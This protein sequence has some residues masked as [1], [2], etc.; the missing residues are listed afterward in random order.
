M[1][2][3][4]EGAA[5]DGADIYLFQQL[6]EA[7]SRSRGRLLVVGIL[8][9]AFDEYAQRLARDLRDEW[10]KVQGRFVDLVV[11][12][13]GDEQ[14]ELLATA[15][16]SDH[17]AKR[18]APLGQSIAK[19]VR[20]GRPSASENLALT[21]S[22]CAPL[23][24]VVAALLGPISRRRFGQN[25]R[26]LFGF[27]N[28]AEPFGFQDFLRDAEDRDLFWPDRLWEYL[29]VNLEPAILASPDGHRWSMAV[30]AVERCVA[31][32]PSPIHLQILKTIALLDLFRE[33]SGL[34][35]SLELLTNCVEGNATEAK[36]SAALK[37]LQSWSFVIFRKHLSCYAIH[38]GS[39]FDIEQALSEAL[40]SIRE[41]NFKQ[42][43]ALAGLQPV[44]AKRHYHSTGALRWFD[45]DLV[46]LAEVAE[47][48]KAPIPSGGA[49]GRF[50]LAVPTANEI[51]PKA[52]KICKEAMAT[53]TGDVVIGLS[54][55]SWQVMRLAREFLAISKVSE[56]RPELSGDAVA[57]REVYARIAD[58]RARLESDLQKMFN[59]AEWYQAHHAAARYSYAE[60]NILAS[61][62]ADTRFNEA[63]RLPNELLNRQNPSSN[64]VAAQKTLLKL[65]VQKEG[66]PRLGID[67]YPAE[68]GLFESI[69]LKAGI[70]RLSQDGWHFCAPSQR[71][72]PC[73][74][75]PAWKA[76]VE[77][78]E[79]NSEKSMSMADLYA[80]WQ[81][82]PYGIKQ[83]LLPVL[84]V[85]FLLAHRDRLAFYREGVFQA[86]FTDLDVDYL[87]TDSNTI[88]L[89]W[90][91]LS[92]DSRK[93]LSGLA[94]VVRELD[95]SNKLVLLQPI[96]VARGLIGIYERLKHWTKRT[97]RL[98]ANALRVRAI[99][100]KASDPNKFLFDDIPALLH[101]VGVRPGQ[102]QSEQVIS[103]VHDGL[104]ELSRAYPEM[105]ERLRQMMLTEL[106]VPNSSRQALAEL[107]ARAKN[108]RQVSGDF[109]LNAFVGRLSQFMASEADMEGI[110]S[111]ATNKPPRDWVDVDLDQAG[112]EIAVLSQQFIRTEAFAHVKGRADKRVAMAVIVG[113]SGRPTP[114]S[115]EFAIADTDR[116]AVNDLIDRVERALAN[117][118]QN[119]RNIILAAL[120]EMSAMYL[121][122]NAE[123]ATHKMSGQRSR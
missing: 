50:L 69:L 103:C 40:G 109:R 86:R 106:D 107:C 34:T 2:K 101:D 88:Q 27:L 71:T 28:S 114:I 105:L 48:A 67:G 58:I 104:A 77:L 117:S 79:S 78:L 59:T 81:N 22:Q 43:K 57:R 8:H 17:K 1:G 100:K 41:V 76:A 94:E 118:D 29:R 52:E 98:S 85:A 97:N 7:A 14:L 24:P 89:R 90:M 37:Q 75:L 99:F 70:Y 15:I 74:L 16:Q 45:V 13:V 102:S 23:H 122:T 18:P 120:A 21:L 54:S 9:Q 65:M 64:A 20:Q 92:R 56:E 53:A 47:R 68:G 121:M 35:A 83:G 84:G 10:A 11:N 31:V 36:V 66:G 63:P 110:A 96:D 91:D 111:L 49:I 82:P 33:R 115:G 123:K 62:L 4:L 51:K 38:A 12:T 113:T 72:D 61:E 25:Q 46:P 5:Q 42:L 26:S 30:E 80:T 3:F 44:L 87:A 116:E 19:V 93:I 112:L 55:A 119:K 95:E 73:G 39:D 60:L 6:A 108:I 32:G